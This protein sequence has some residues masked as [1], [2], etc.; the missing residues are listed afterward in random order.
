MG[1]VLANFMHTYIPIKKSILMSVYGI[2]FKA[3][4]D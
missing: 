4:R 2:D 1:F 3:H